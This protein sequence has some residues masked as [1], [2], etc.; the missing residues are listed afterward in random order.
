MNENNPYIIF[1]LSNIYESK[2]GVSTKY[3]NFLNNISEEYNIKLFLPFKEKKYEKYIINKN[4]IKIIK[5][6]G[7][8]IPF[9]KDILIP[10]INKNDLKNEIINGNEIIV[11]NGE[12]IWIYKILLNLKN[13]FNNIKIFPTM[14]TDY[15]YY[16]KNI[17]LNYNFVFLLRNLDIY[18]ENKLM[19]GIIVTGEKMKEKYSAH[20]NN[21]FNANEV[22]LDVFKNPK[23]DLYN[24]NFYN[25]IYC[26]RISK[27]KNL[28]EILDCCYIL[29]NNNINFIL[30]IIGDG[31]F[32]KEFINLI[33]NKYFDIKSI[34]TFHGSK[35]QYEIN[36]IY[37]NLDN[38]IF[39]FTSLSETFGKTPMEAIATGI[40]ILIKKSEASE[41]L[42][43]NKKNA[44]IFDSPVDFLEK[45]IFFKNL[46]YIDKKIFIQ[47]S[48]NNILKYE[49]KNIFYNM[50]NFIMQENIVEKKKENN[51]GFFDKF[52]IYGISKFMN[53]TGNIFG[54]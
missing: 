47:N 24:N 22:N 45:F 29:F 13:E 43:I 25:F 33:E 16:A 40:P 18:L 31:P 50:I 46:Q 35:E 23:F 7:L 51:L 30:N 12:F 11:F 37:Q 17:Y 4:K 14:H 1:I 53:C 19:N 3:I 48:I 10:I 28:Q 39:I 8:K 52:T 15:I 9:Y 21:V 42:Y 44:L 2:N 32:L 41:Y 6:K 26:G 38:R 49:Q 27:E 54:E 36:H 5:C 34:I 20:T